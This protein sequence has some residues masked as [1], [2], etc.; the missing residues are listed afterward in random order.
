MEILNFPGL[1]LEFELTKVA[2]SIFGWPIHW[3]GLIIATAFLCGAIYALARTKAF[4]VDA[5]RLMDV[6]LCAVL[7]GV[8]GARL[9]FVLF[10]LDTYINNPIS[11]FFTWEGGIAIYGGLIGAV[12]ATLIVCKIR[13]VR[14]LPCLDNLVGGV[15]LG[16]AIGRWGNFVNIEA[17]GSNTTAPWG[18]TSPSIEWYLTQQRDAL[19]AIGVLVDPSLPVHPTFLY[20]SLWCLLGF[21]LI[22]LY[23]K[24]R[25]FDGELSLIYSGWYGLG[26]FWIE[27]LRTDSLLI[28]TVR[29]SQLVALLCVIASALTLVLIHSKI[30]REGDPGYLQLYA[31][32]N[33]GQAVLSGEFYKKSSTEKGEAVSREADTT[34]NGITAASEAAPEPGEDTP[35]TQSK[36]EDG[37]DAE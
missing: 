27:G 19:K 30:R 31:K 37:E 20:E 1:G 23:T 36:E 21:L 17:F 6:I 15:I 12:L 9:Y 3:Y 25:R 28:G 13:R 33:E 8:V 10:S 29:I 34:E 16:Q 35:A 18:M 11:I 5:D 22:A 4:A 2:F 26:R 24:H 14:L 7:F 32:T